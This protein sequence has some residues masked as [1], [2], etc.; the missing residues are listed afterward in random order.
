MA[1]K[2]HRFNGLNKDIW[3]PDNI[4][5]IVDIVP[6]WRTNIRSNQKFSGQRYTTWHDTGNPSSNAMGERNW[7]HSGAGGSYVGYNF[8]VDANRI[9]QLIPLDEVTWHAGTAEGN[10][11]SWGMEQ[12]LNTD[13]NA[14]FR[15]CAALQG[16]LCAAMGWNVDVALVQHNKWYGKHCP[17]QIRNKGLWPSAVAMARDFA[18]QA[19][20]AAGGTQPTEPTTPTVPTH[21]IPGFDGTKDVTING[22][23]YHAEKKSITLTSATNVRQW[24]STDAGVVRLAEAGKID[25][26]GWV[27]GEDVDGVKKW[28]IVSDGRLWAGTTEEEATPPPPPPVEE[29]VKV[30]T[31]KNVYKGAVFY[32]AGSIEVGRGVK[33]ARAGKG[34]KISSTTSEVVQELKEGDEFMARLWCFGETVDGENTWWLA[35]TGNEK[36]PFEEC[37]RIPAAITTQRPE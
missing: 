14:T 4:Q 26:L 1:M 11:Y 21:G 12:C 35:G 13:W 34:Y 16:A 24:A 33:I 6:S 28:W 22:T 7:L 5:V 2:K 31:G 32:S 23:V 29:E 25:V 30:V 20:A 27:D 37:M 9:I 15:T 18:A 17:A 3:L 10:K 36:N 19:R 8:A